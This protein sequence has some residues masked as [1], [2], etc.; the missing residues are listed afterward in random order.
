[1]L[2]RFACALVVAATVAMP[3]TAFDMSAMSDTERQ[4]FRDEIRAYL[5][6]NPEVLIE[7]I[8]VLEQRQ[9]DA[10]L[11]GDAQM[12]AAN[13]EALF[14]DGYSHVAGN[15]DGDITIVEFLDY[16]CGYC[17]KAH[18]DVNAL[19][20]SD[21]NIRFIIKEFPILGEE[22]TMAS[23]F[24]ISTKINAGDEAYFDIHNALMEHN[25]RITEGSLRRLA[26]SHDLDD[27]AIIDGMDDA[28]VD[29]ILQAN[30]VLAQTMAI[31]GTPGFVMGETM[32]RGYAPLASMQEIVAQERAR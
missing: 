15:P 22:S 12:I 23:R 26:K 2:K 14:N 28:V 29:Q 25:G 1:M 9:A 16:R 31:T 13:A 17:K 5:L 11:Q 30:Y 8:N 7:A 24:A 10:Q 27:D 6:E 19:L 20:E 3:A 32:V 21:G 18:P 4:A